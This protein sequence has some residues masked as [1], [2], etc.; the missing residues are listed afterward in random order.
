MSF[1]SVAAAFTERVEG[2]RPDQWDLPAPCEGWVARD[3]V[4]HL[5]T[6][7]PAFFAPELPLPA[8]TGDPVADWRALRDALQAAYDDPQVSTSLVT[9]QAGT[10]P[11][12]QAIDMFVLGDVFVH[13]WDLAR[14]TGQDERLDEEQAAGMLAGMEPI[15]EVLR[16]SGHYGPRVAVPDDADVVTRLIAFTGRDPSW[17]AAT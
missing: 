8:A 12:G 3:V 15:D 11:V 1:T 5:T 6:W 17:P 10:H 2:V 14:A 16:G 4:D 13:T 7:V 9:S